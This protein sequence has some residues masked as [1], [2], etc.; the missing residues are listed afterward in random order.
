VSRTINL[1]SPSIPAA[2]VGICALPAADD[3]SQ[4]HARETEAFIQDWL[5][6]GVLYETLG[7]AAVKSVYVESNP[8]SSHGGITTAAL[9]EQILDRL[10]Y[11]NHLWDDDAARAW[12][13][14]RRAEKL[15]RA[16]VR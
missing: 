16:V 2:E 13:L 7:E 4:K 11:I 6:F 8:T 12:S 5:Y 10:A 3:F 9:R 14:I 1:I 15:L